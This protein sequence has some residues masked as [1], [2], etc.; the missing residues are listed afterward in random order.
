MSKY[1]NYLKLWN[2]FDAG[3]DDLDRLFAEVK[4]KRIT[5]N[6][7][8]PNQFEFLSKLCNRFIIL[9]NKNL[10]NSTIRGFR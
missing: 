3:C 4:G 1:E 6:L 7:K 2:E 9:P 5:S 8:V 10:I